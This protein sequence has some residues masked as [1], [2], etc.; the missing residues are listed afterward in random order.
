MRQGKALILGKGAVNINRAL[1]WWEAEGYRTKCVDFDCEG[2][3]LADLKTFDLVYLDASLPGRDRRS[4]RT[5]IYGT[6]IPI[7]VLPHA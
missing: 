1:A 7:E 3:H 6:G 5:T 4:F 2:L